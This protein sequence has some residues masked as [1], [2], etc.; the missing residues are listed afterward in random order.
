MRFSLAFKPK[1][2]PTTQWT[3]KMLSDRTL[4]ATDAL[5]TRHSS[6]AQGHENWHKNKS[7]ANL[8]K[9]KP[10]LKIK[11]IALSNI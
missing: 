5:L 8:L 3:S 7:D 11:T 1:G 4:R 2:S 10:V 6:S 9:S